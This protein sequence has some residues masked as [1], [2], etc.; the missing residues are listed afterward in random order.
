[1]KPAVNELEKASADREKH[2]E[3]I[4]GSSLA[5]QTSTKQI[6]CKS[7]VP[8]VAFVTKQLVPEHL[9]RPHGNALQLH[10]AC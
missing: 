4:C 7:L 10:L 9:E 8:G 1:M 3:I 5:A 6:I 2:T